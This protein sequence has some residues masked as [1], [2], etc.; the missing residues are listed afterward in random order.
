MD[1][2]NFL[3]IFMFFSPLVFHVLGEWFENT[4]ALAVENDP[5]GVVAQAVDGCSSEQAIGKCLTPLG[6]IEIAGDQGSR[7]FISFG[8]QI[9]K[10]FI[11]R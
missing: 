6:E 3:S 7:A 10:I 2:V 5:V 11:L 4:I 8:D 9:V 1:G